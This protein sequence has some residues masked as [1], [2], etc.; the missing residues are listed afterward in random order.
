MGFRVEGAKFKVEGLGFKAFKTAHM[1]NHEDCAWRLRHE[2][3]SRNREERFRFRVWG[4][5]LGV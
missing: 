1:H 5:G 4:L 2:A 3:P